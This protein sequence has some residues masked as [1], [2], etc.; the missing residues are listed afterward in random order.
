[1]AGLEALGTRVEPLLAEA[2]IPASIIADL[3][4]HLPPR[5]MPKL[6]E[7]AVAM[8]NDDCLGIHIAEAT[9][10]NAFDV[11]A[12]AMLSSPTLRDAFTPCSS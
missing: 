9:P 3:D 12:Y 2:G 11:H 8:T 6:W 10:V 4:A 5:S 7:R 1:M